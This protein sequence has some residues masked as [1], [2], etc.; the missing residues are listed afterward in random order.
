MGYPSKA[1]G[2]TV[3]NT[4]WNEVA[5]QGL[6]RFASTGARD[7]AIPTPV[8]GMRI[9]LSSI[10][11]EQMYDGV[12]WIT[13]PP[14][15]HSWE[16]AA[17]GYAS[18]VQSPVPQSTLSWENG[19][20]WASGANQRHTVP[21]TSGSRMPYDGVHTVSA[22]LVWAANA[23]GIRELSLRL[24]GSTI[25]TKDTKNN[26]G[27]SVTVGHTLSWTGFLSGGD[28]I[29]ALAYQTSGGVLAQVAN[30]SYLSSAR[31]AQ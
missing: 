2:N 5:G 14:G 13:T 4:E 27:A 28:Y 19:D 17:T 25:I 26:L 30:S 8:E 12:A 24:N 16:A 31:L 18:G 10:V 7:A 3:S 23:T 20:Y 22:G 21:P 6:M 1:A 29:E 9:Y 15:A 11:R